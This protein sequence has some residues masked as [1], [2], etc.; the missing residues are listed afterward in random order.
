MNI[1]SALKWVLLASLGTAA[2]ACASAPEEAE[3]ESSASPVSSITPPPVSCENGRC[4]EAAGPRA[5]QRSLVK[6]TT[7]GLREVED[8]RVDQKVRIMP[9]GTDV[10]V[11]K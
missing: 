6:P 11:G 7:R 8:L 1:Q 5:D 10:T 3:E 2:V 4:G 9:D